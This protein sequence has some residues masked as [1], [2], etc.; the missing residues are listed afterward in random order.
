MENQNKTGFR[1]L[2]MMVGVE[3]HLTGKNS[4]RQM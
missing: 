1:K 3:N 2:E 4:L